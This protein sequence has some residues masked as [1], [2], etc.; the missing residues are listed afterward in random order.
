[1]IGVANATKKTA[2]LGN[3]SFNL[4]MTCDESQ[5]LVFVS[6][7]ESWIFELFAVASNFKQ[8]LCVSRIYHNFTTPNDNKY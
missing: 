6:F 7:L 3:F 1:M 8:R 5:S 2:G 4:R